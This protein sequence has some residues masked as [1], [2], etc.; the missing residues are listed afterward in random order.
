MATEGAR[1]KLPIALTNLAHYTAPL[2][3]FGAS[4]LGRLFVLAI[5]MAAMTAFTISDLQ[6]SADFC[7][8]ETVN[9]VMAASPMASTNMRPSD[10]APKRRSGA[11][12]CARFVSAIGGFTRAPSVAV[13][14]V[15]PDPHLSTNYAG[16]MRTASRICHVAGA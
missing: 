7:K 2:R 11:V 12:Y 16:D 10:D 14:G 8:S 6:K 9:A 15:V 3:R 13:R 5:G 1:V 4:S